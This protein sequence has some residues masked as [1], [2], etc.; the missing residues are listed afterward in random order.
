MTETLKVASCSVAELLANHPIKLS[1]DKISGKLIIPEYQRP[2]TWQAKEMSK[3]FNDL[4]SY[5]KALSKDP[6]DPP[7]VINHKYY[8]GSIILH[9]EVNED[10]NLNRLNIIDGQQRVTSLAILAYWLKHELQPEIIYNAPS[11]QQQIAKNIAYLENKHGHDYTKLKTSINFDNINI[12][13]VVTKSEDDAY[14][15]FETQN[16]GGVRLNGADI[17]KAHHLRATK[18][19]IQDNYA[20]QWEALGELSPLLDSVMKVRYWQA[21]KFKEMPSQRTPHLIKAEVVNE[22]AENCN[23]K[24]TDNIA[25]RSVQH[26]KHDSGWHINTPETGFA[27]RQPL[28]SGINTIDYLSY[29][30]NLK[31]SLLVKN[32][33]IS[34]QD[35]FIAFYSN[36]LIQDT[37]GT[38]Y[39]KRLFDTTLLLY[40]SQFGTSQ[41]FEAALWLFRMVY[42]PRVKN[43]KSVRESTIQAFV[44]D[45]HLFDIIMMSFN[46]QQLVDSLRQF[47]YTCDSANTEDKNTKGRYI[48]RVVTYFN[49]KLDKI[50]IS[51][52]FDEMLIE[53][54]LN[55]TRKARKTEEVY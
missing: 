19:N 51:S 13:L 11:S 35:D 22:L 34:N 17:I 31:Q 16:T 3:L 21:F 9:Q 32:S 53:G 26:I 8:L 12:T 47:R 45:H 18:T 43:Q 49:L 2:Y 5:F 46:H 7:K 36:D 24:S 40:V 42:S 54:I 29:F 33:K 1:D 23:N 28:N 25:Y 52:D 44:R 15:F 30:A 20:R 27:M 10:E 6:N 41:L 14:R 48:N 38:A 37:H 50:K 39:L 4:L 55:Q